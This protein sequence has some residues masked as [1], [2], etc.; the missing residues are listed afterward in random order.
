[1]FNRTGHI[2]HPNPRAIYTY[3]KDYCIDNAKNHPQYPKFIW[4]PKIVDVGC[5]GGFGSNILSLEGDFVWGIDTD[6]DSIRWCNQVF[7]RNKNNI[8]YSSQLSF[9]VINVLDE[10]REIMAFDIVAAIEIIE[11][12]NEYDKLLAFIKRLCKREKN[13]N[14]VQAPEATTVFIS[15]PNRNNPGIRDNQPYNK[16]HVREWTP[17]EMYDIMTAN[18][19]HVVLMNIHGEP[20]DLDMT[21]EVMLFKCEVPL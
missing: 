11:H 16:M 15:S 12:I 9:E 18:F 14:Y 17:G 10:P 13:G 19:K 4:K 8:Y 2:L 6:K 7:A 20:K 3:I 5:G 1:M 21:D